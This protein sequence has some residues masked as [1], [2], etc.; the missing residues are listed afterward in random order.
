MPDGS[1]GAVGAKRTRDFDLPKRVYR[2]N[3]AFWY[4]DYENKWHRLAPLDDYPGM[5]KALGALL[6]TDEVPRTVELLWAKYQVDEFPS[7]ARKTQQGRRND[8]KWPLKVFGK[9]DAQDVEPHHIWTFWRD[10]GRTE[11]ARHEIR[12]FSVLMTYARQVGARKGPENSNPC[13][14]LKLPGAKARDLYVTDEMFYAVHDIA[15]PM[16]ALAMELAWCAGLDEG[17]ILRLERKH[18]IDTGLLFERGKTGKY[19]LVEGD[20]LVQIVKA[21][22]KERPQVRRS[23]ICARN[24]R[25]YAPN[26]FQSAWQR[27][28]ND[29]I[30]SGRLPAQQRYH[31]H[32]LRGKAASEA[33]SDEAAMN[34]LGH[35]DKQ[36][37]RKHYRRLPQRSQALRIFPRK[38]V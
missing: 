16:I 22:L 12:A 10:R 33:E 34:L 32:D 21:A 26:G 30:E 23:I 24:G 7:L 35:G 37:T 28:M 20:D 5:L 17:T 25:A 6:N 8:M 36:I 1:L 13:F 29:A 31:F 15:P 18:V 14:D 38:P 19:Q 11:Q 4:V 2:K 3:G 27:V 9:M